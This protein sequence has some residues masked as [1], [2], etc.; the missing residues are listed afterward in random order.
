MIEQHP[1]LMLKPE[2][3]S[4]IEKC[5][6]EAEEKRQLTATV[7]QLIYDCD[8]FR[9]LIP[10]EYGG[11]EWPLPK[12]VA[13]FEALAWAD[14]NVGWCVNLG[15]GANMFA[16]YLDPETARGI[17]SHRE[18]CCA[19]SGAV[20]GVATRV[21]GGYQVSGYW[22]YAS[23]TAHA[24]HFTA[25]CYL[26]DAQRKPVEEAGSPEFRSFLFP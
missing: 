24:T 13:L 4:D 2:W 9:I 12:A 7:L 26:Y 10:K 20:S 25:N 16:G 14:G 18:V 22:K 19:G 21:T 1:K 17:F 6:A 23:G 5:S 11:K 8:W 3:V 15:A